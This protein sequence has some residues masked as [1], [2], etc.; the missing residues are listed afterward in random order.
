[1]KHS[2]ILSVNFSHNFDTNLIPIH[3]NNKQA[4][5]LLDSGA[6]I[7]CISMSLYNKI[8]S[9]CSKLQKSSY[10]E[11]YGVGGEILHVHGSVTASFQIGNSKFSQVFHVFQKLHND[12]ILGID[13]LQKYRCI[14][15]FSANELKI[16]REII[17]TISPSSSSSSC[18][19]LARACADIT[20]KPRGQ[21]VIPVRL[22]KITNN[23]VALIEP[24]STLNCM[25]S[26]CLIRSYSGKSNF[27]LLNPFDSDIQIRKSQVVGKIFATDAVAETKESLTQSTQ[28]KCISNISLQNEEKFLKNARDLGID[29]SNANLT[30]EQKHK[31][32]LFLGKNSDIFALQNSSIGCTD[33]HFHKIE[34]GASPPVRQRPYRQSPQAR[35]EIEK[36][37]Q[38]MLNDGIIEESNSMWGSAIILVKKKN[39]A[40]RFAIDFRA[41]NKVTTPMFF[42]IPTLT[43]VTD[44][45]AN[46]KAKIFSALDLKSS[47]WQIPL[48]P[49]TAHKTAFVTGD[50][51]YQFKR[52]PYGLTNAP[53]AFQCVMTRALAGLNYKIVLIYI[54][55]LLCFSS[56][57]ETH[58]QNLDAIFQRLRSAN[59]KLNPA[60]CQFGKEKVEYLGHYL[61]KDGLEASPKTVDA[62]KSFPKPKSVKQLRS[63]LGMCNFFRKF[64]MNFSKIAFPLNAL[65]KKDAKFTWSDE[66]EKA[67]NTLKDKLT[68]TPILALPDMDKQFRITV[69]A[70]QTGIGYF[71]SQLDDEGKEKVVSYGGRSLH[72]HEKA[73]AVT[74]LEGLA[75]V[76]AVKE[77]HPY[78]A[79]GKFKIFTD[80]RGLQWLKNT[81]DPHGRL[82]RWSLKLSPYNYEILYKPGS[83]NHVTDALSRRP[84][85]CENVD[86]VQSAEVKSLTA[87][88]KHSMQRDSLE[89]L[90]SSTKGK[91][92][93]C[94]IEFEHEPLTDIPSVSLIDTKAVN[95]NSD[96]E[97]PIIP[98][99]V[100]KE[101]HNVISQHQWQTADLRPILEY[102][103]DG[104]VPNDQVKAIKL[105]AESE[106]YILDNDVLY[107]FYFVRAKGQFP[108]SQMIRQLAVPSEYRTD[109]L[110]CYHDGPGGAHLAFE[111]S[112]ASIRNK[113][114]WP[115]MW[116]DIQSYVKSCDVCQKATRNYSNHKAPLQPLPIAEPFMRVH[117]DILGPLPET[118]EGFKY[119]LSVVDSFTG[120]I[121]CIP[122]KNQQADTVAR[123]LYKEIFCRYGSPFLIIS[124]QGS[125]FM[126]NL[127]Q[128]L[129]ELFNV[130]RHRTTAFH[131][132]ANGRVE[133]MNSSIGKCLR[134]YCMDKQEDWDIHLPGVLMGLRMSCNSSSQYS[135]YQMLFGRVM[136]HPIDHVL[137]PKQFLSKSTKQ[138]L[139]DIQKS[140][141]ITHDI[142]KQNLEDKQAKQKTLY[143]EKAK[144]PEFKLG[145]KVLL[146]NNIQEIGKSRKL[147]PK[148]KGPYQIV[149]IGPPFTYLLMDINTQVVQTSYVNAN[150]L[151][152]YHDRQLRSSD[153]SKP[154]D[155]IA[156]YE[157]ILS[158]KIQKGS[159][160][161][162]VKLLNQEN[163]YWELADLVPEFLRK[164]YHK[165]HTRQGK[166]KKPRKS[167]LKYFSKS[168]V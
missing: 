112:F 84:Y 163:P 113:Y 111:K 96:F 18:I 140:L 106:N 1:M 125:N 36:Q 61:S 66:C 101:A 24:I 34:T 128:A 4:H 133:V 146:Q 155:Q 151:K 2:K 31:L 160:F 145:D 162:K 150:R 107:H 46:S 102:L 77:Y 86:T 159:Q 167:S 30:S 20:L 54:D 137:L 17:A 51:C 153:N 50:N 118:L 168:K 110:Q 33:L 93:Y 81:K 73:W 105:V 143:D 42:P 90:P 72:K 26:K 13:F 116:S 97:L 60:K 100:D 108:G 16:N 45:V 83:T 23:T 88:T 63:F 117:M 148:Y 6:H 119:I 35:E 139:A 39:G 166:K 114:F 82:Y 141:Q 21:T 78:I 161:Y 127:V 67:F 7:S 27:L 135:P 56:D 44:C 154:E 69:D 22:S 59:L 95:H 57:F 12:L 3:F 19:G 131:P 126:S 49:E 71:L 37:I 138:H 144:E 152:L 99:K 38:E 64:V 28:G 48:D 103:R 40:Y 104:I 136:R 94:E 164:E 10:S 80:H 91:T 29:L 89:T 70:S 158:A 74:E 124:D 132:M 129:C 32:L 157:K 47:F 109:I 75:I 142:A 156:V 41:L 62:I 147:S 9:S 85:E 149:K 68:S 53:M 25:G 52:V 58:L 14:V 123:V 15:D 122:M 79:G 76:E 115:K 130:K 165:T 121:E 120:W 92:I 134:A 98:T 8:K 5:A 65:L 11:V 55:D 43:E 87:N